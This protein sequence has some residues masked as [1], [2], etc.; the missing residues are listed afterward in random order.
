M[1]QEP[2]TIRRQLEP[3][4]GTIEQLAALVRL[5]VAQLVR[6][7]EDAPTLYTSFEVLKPNNQT[8]TI[9]P[10]ARRLRE[11]Q[12]SMLDILQECVRYPRWMMGGVPK[13]SIFD[14]ASPHVGR[15]MVATFDV[16][17]FYPSTKPVMVR[18]VLERLGLR[19]VAAD[20][21][22]G[23]VVKDDELPQGGPTSGFLANLALEPADR[24]I[25][26]LCRKHGLSFT[27]YVD[28]MAI[29]GER[30]LRSFQGA[31]IEAVEA[32]GYVVA[33]DKIHCMRRGEA[34]LVTKLRVNNK[35]RPT[36]EFIAEVKSDIWDCL[37]NGA[38]TVA[39]EKA[40]PLHKLK[41]SLTGKVA[42]IRA[43][44]AAS[45]KKLQGMLYGV[46]W[47]QPASNIDPILALA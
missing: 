44:D 40:V 12:R 21:V 30:D 11:L 1:Q 37:N 7:V 13:R 25:D 41:N 32:C 42:H 18:A 17:A 31:V 14:H 23:L 28:D 39:A 29:S 45:G 38:V 47:S 22:L 43:A 9:R 35:L 5:P 27:R 24:R 46:N 34:Q 2:P 3:C 16:E 20:A 8:R 15:H 26:A 36:R 19:D 4:V 6:L 33:P 10:P